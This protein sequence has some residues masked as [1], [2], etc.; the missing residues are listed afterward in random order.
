MSIERQ[1]R[2]KDE[3]NL[4]M[5]NTDQANVW[6]EQDSCRESLLSLLGDTR[7]QST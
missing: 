1:R 4:L 5:S 3:G 7:I 6:K 2:N